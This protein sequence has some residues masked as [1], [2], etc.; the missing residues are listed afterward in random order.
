MFSV[1]IP[2]FSLLAPLIKSKRGV[3]MLKIARYVFAALLA[4]LLLN[5]FSCSSLKEKDDSVI[6][7]RTL[8]AKSLP[9]SHQKKQSLATNMYFISCDLDGDGVSEAV[10][11]DY[12]EQMDLEKHEMT[13]I[14]QKEL[15]FTHFSL[16]RAYP[17]YISSYTAD[18]NSD[19]VKDIFLIGHPKDKT[20]LQIIT[21]EEDTL[22]TWMLSNPHRSNR[23]W[24][25]DLQIFAL[26][27]VTGDGVPEVLI[28]VSTGDAYWPRGIYALDW[29]KSRVVWHFDTGCPLTSPQLVDIDGD[30]SREILCG[31]TAPDNGCGAFGESR[32][33]IN[34]TD[35]THT[36]LFAIDS[37]GHEI[38]RKKIGDVPYQ[39]TKVYGH[40]I[41]GD[42]RKEIF[43]T[44]G[45][46]DRPHWARWD[47]V[48]GNTNPKLV[49]PP[50]S[51]FSE[52]TFMDMD[53]DGDDDILLAMS[54]G[55]ILCYD[56]DFD[57]L[58]KIKIEGMHLHNIFPCDL[59]FDNKQ[60]LVISGKI[61]DVNYLITLDRLLRPNSCLKDVNQIDKISN[62][63]VEIGYGRN[64]GFIIGEK[65]KMIFL[66]KSQ[67]PL[68]T[69]IAWQ[70]LLAGL[71]LG[72]AIVSGAGYLME[73]KKRI[74]MVR[75]IFPVVFHD[76]SV[77]YL[78][79]DKAGICKETN[80]FMERL[81]GK[82]Q[83]AVVGKKY[84]DV[85]KGSPFE[86]IIAEF[87]RAFSEGSWLSRELT[88][89]E[90]DREV[91]LLAS[92]TLLPICKGLKDY[93]LFLVQDVS[94]PVRTKRAIAWA[95]MVQKLA[96]EI[97]TPLSTV[98]LS[99]QQLY[100]VSNRDGA[101]PAILKYTSHIIE[102][103]ERLHGLTDAFMK[104]ASIE[105]PRR[106]TIDL[107]EI[108]DDILQDARFY[109]GSGIE[110][111]RDEEEGLPPLSGDPQQLKIVFNNILNN[112]LT[113]MKGEGL[114]RIRSRL[115]QQLREE[116]GVSGESE[117]IR[118][119]ISDSGCGMSKEEMAQLFQPFFS[120]SA[121]GTGMGLVIVKKII[122]DHRGMIQI[123]SNKNIGTT[124]ILNLPTA[125]R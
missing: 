61:D 113:A 102:Q 117:M 92:L 87:D 55:S 15:G 69:S 31:S 62:S 49:I 78:L 39:V 110:V 109:L 108:L 36:Y 89:K 63:I 59:N 90:W 80:S 23:Y 4:G 112:A 10:G 17:T 95:S 26:M 84:P 71:L 100:K 46:N 122:E 40:D 51:Y 43:Y 120:G 37:L 85:F 75:K 60:E 44:Y 88:G 97:K 118:I 91:H 12:Y 33:V 2:N 68:P 24:Y 64:K 22:C 79:L 38:N 81:L 107:K 48:T 124:V 18:V 45:N 99:A 1:R 93:R 67:L 47:P 27:D 66:F 70:E 58:K 50:G 42:G 53:R 83:A 96:H 86:S 114:I 123:H 65:E 13:I 8:D 77:G 115:V 19:G 14:Y 7:I 5:L 32:D 111:Q 35:D 52:A 57:I 72:I 41:N 34:G 73:E 104:F 30:G 9:Y 20:V 125:E 54:D 21:A 74:R 103:V 119:E 101:D 11:S 3:S 6:D 106:D 56:D 25:C 16:R 28:N 94:A 98:M 76:D 29:R 116:G 105:K 82:P 121:Q